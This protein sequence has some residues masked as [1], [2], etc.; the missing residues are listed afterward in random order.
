MICH[1][2]HIH[3]CIFQYLYM[4]A[5]MHICIRP[6]M[7]VWMCVCTY[8]I[9]Y[10][11][12][13]VRLFAPMDVCIHACQHAYMYVYE[14]MHVFM[15]VMYVCMRMKILQ[16][17]VYGENVITECLRCVH[18][19][20]VHVKSVCHLLYVCVHDLAPSYHSRSPKFCH[21]FEGSLK[22]PRFWT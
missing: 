8:V 7:R 14:C 1:C 15:H 13:Y 21:L 12:N 2:V 17:L 5:C 22:Y 16:V 9:M 20:A 4:H 11:C 3:A 18:D 19:T 6:C 10:V